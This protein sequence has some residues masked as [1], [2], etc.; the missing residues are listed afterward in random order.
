VL[1]A[2]GTPGSVIVG[3]GACVVPG[4]LRG[5]CQTHPALNGGA[6]SFRLLRRLELLLIRT[7]TPEVALLLIRTATPQSDPA[8]RL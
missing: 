8:V 6:I 7:A 3:K 5:R 1:F 4:A 2:V